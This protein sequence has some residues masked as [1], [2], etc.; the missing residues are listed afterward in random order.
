MKYAPI[1]ACALVA[2]CSDSASVPESP[3]GRLKIRPNEPNGCA[4]NGGACDVNVATDNQVTLLATASGGDASLSFAAE[5]TAPASAVVTGQSVT[6]VCRTKDLVALEIPLT[7]SC[8]KG[9]EKVCE[10]TVVVETKAAGTADIH[11][12]GAK[13]ATVDFAR[14]QVTTPASVTFNLTGFGTMGWY[15]GDDIAINGEV[16]AANNIFLIAPLNRWTVTS[17][18]PAVVQLDPAD[19][20]KAKAIGIGTSDLTLSWYGKTEA[21][22]VNVAAPPPPP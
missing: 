10:Y 20:G 3:T 21:K 4:I 11:F 1:L 9:L 15:V 17:S 2:A 22:Q 8:D 13:G 12:T 19:A 6:C 14:L 16:Y 7:G 18:N 5:S